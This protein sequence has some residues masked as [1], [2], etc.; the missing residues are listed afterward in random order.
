[1]DSCTSRHVVFTAGLLKNVRTRERGFI[2]RGFNGDRERSNMVGDLGPFG[3]AIYVERARKNILS[4]G[5]LLLD[6]HTVRLAGNG[7]FEVDI[8]GQTHL[9]RMT[10]GGLF[11]SKVADISEAC[12]ASGL[13]TEEQRALQLTKAQ[14]AG[15][16]EARR[17]EE[18]LG[19]A[20]S[21][22]LTYAISKGTINEATFTARDVAIA[23]EVY[24]PSIPRM[25]W[26]GTQAAAHR[27]VVIAEGAASVLKDVKLHS[28]VFALQGKW[29]ILS[30]VA[31]LRQL[32][33]SEAKRR[34]NL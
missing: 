19:F 17:A 33:T 32:L 26:K 18:L 9:F 23:P 30:V 6:G 14:L 34:R 12:V 11:A 21:T 31:L 10:P 28:D 1:M 15:A 24:G 20:S 13:E 3:E 5:Q 27:N 7:G 2:V 22:A 29:L 25:L 4:L 8:G 16:K